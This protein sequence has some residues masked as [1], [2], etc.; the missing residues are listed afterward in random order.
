MN[1]KGLRIGLGV[2]RSLIIAVGA[3]LLIMIAGSSVSE[4]TFS[5]GMAN[6]GGKLDAVYNLTLVVLAIC[7]AGAVL[8]GIVYFLMNFKQ[9]M[10]TLIGIIGFVVL[11]AISFYVLADDTV[12]RAYESSGI[13]VSNGESLFAGGGIILVYLLGG[14]TFLAIIWTE[15]SKLLK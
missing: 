1:D 8:F 6:Y 10:G 11:A 12:L 4:E 9:R 15:I 3:I 7:A 14:L 2:V 5:E 13:E